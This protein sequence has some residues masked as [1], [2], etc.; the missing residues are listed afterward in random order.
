[1]TSGGE[2]WAFGDKASLDDP[3]PITVSWAARNRLLDD[4]RPASWTSAAVSPEP[5]QRHYVRV[6]RRV[7]RNASEDAPAVLVAQF[8]DLE[9]ST[10]Q[11]PQAVFA[12][13]MT[14]EDWNTGGVVSDIEY[15]AAF[16]IEVG[17]QRGALADGAIELSAQAALM[18][19]DVGTAPGGWGLNYG[20][21]YGGT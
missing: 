5:G 15:G 8:Y 3:Q 9:G 1:M 12:D 4:A 20:N 10:F 16:A 2:T 21:D 18:L 19:V 7:R 14:N 6:W 13:A 11:I 17:A